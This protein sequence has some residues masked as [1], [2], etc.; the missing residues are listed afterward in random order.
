MGHDWGSVRGIVLWDG[1]CGVLEAL[2]CVVGCVFRTPA[3]ACLGE[4]VNMTQGL[5][6]SSLNAKG[7]A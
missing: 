4:I 2:A 6:H 1:S 3:P 7:A 5:L